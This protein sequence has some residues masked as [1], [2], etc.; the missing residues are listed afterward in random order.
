MAVQAT[1]NDTPGTALP[2]QSFLSMPAGVLS[3]SYIHSAG[4]CRH[5]ACCDMGGCRHAMQILSWA[6][7][8]QK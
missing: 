7:V 4:F 2:Q 3:C 1:Q 5:P 6:L 8:T